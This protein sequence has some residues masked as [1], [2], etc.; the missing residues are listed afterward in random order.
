M[1]ILRT[2]LF[3]LILLALLLTLS[4]IFNHNVDFWVGKEYGYYQL[5][6]T[7]SLSV[8]LFLISK[9]QLIL[10]KVD[11]A[12]IS[13]LLFLALSRS[14]RLN[15]F[16]EIHIINTFALIF[17]YLSLK[18][19]RLNKNEMTTYYQFI[20]G[21]GI[22]LCGYC[23]LELFNVIEPTKFYWTITG[24][25]PNPGPL[26]GFI[27]LILPLVFYELVQ[28][29]ILK[30]PIKL[31]LYIISALLMLFV[32]IKSESRAAMLSTVIALTILLSYYGFK[33]WKYFK[34][35][36][37]TLLPIISTIVISK[38]TGSINGRLL[39][40]KISLLSFLENPFSGVGY[41][42]F[43]VEYS[44]FQAEYFSKGG[45]TE[46]ILLAGANEQAFNEFL[47]FVVENGVLG[48]ILII[49]ALFWISQAKP[50]VQNSDKQ[51][52]PLVSIAFY[53]S[54]AIFSF[55]SFPLQF[56]AFKLLLLNQIG[57]QNYTPLTVNFKT[58]K[59]F[60]KILLGSAAC[61]LL[62]TITSHYKAF[63]AWKEASELQFLNP[64]S[65]KELF[66]LAYQQL[67]NDGIFLLRYGS[68]TE[69]KNLNKALLLYEK[70][71][72]LFNFP[73]LY[74]RTANLY[75]KQL[76]YKNAEKNL[77]KIHYISPHFA[78][79]FL[80]LLMT[81]CA[82]DKLE[83]Q[84]NSITN[85]ENV[86]AYDGDNTTIKGVIKELK[87]GTNRASLER[88]LL[89]NDVLWENAEPL[90]IEDKKRILVPFLSVDKENIIGFFALYRDDKGKTQYDMTV[91]SDVYNKK[92]KLP[93]WNSSIWAGYFTAYDRTILGKRNGNPGVLKKA[94]PK[95]QLN[96]MT[97][98]FE[99][100]CYNVPY[101]SC[102]SVGDD[103]YDNYTGEW[104]SCGGSSSTYC[105]TYYNW[106][107]FTYW[108]D[109]EPTNPGTGDDGSGGGGTNSPTKSITTIE[110]RI[111]DLITDP[112]TSQ[113]FTKLKNLNNG[114]IP[115]MLNHFRA[116]GTIF[117]LNISIGNV[118]QSG[119]EAETKIGINHDTANI[120]LNQDYINGTYYANRP[121]DLSIANTITHEIIHAY[122]ISIT[123]A[124][125][126]HNDQEL[127]NSQI[128][129]EAYKEYLKTH[130]PEILPNAH[131][132]YIA[133]K[134]VNSIAATIKEFH[135]GSSVYSS[136][137]LADQVYRD[138][139]WAGLFDT[140]I[141]N[142]KYPNDPGNIHFT[143]RTRI[144]DRFYAERNG[145][146]RGQ[147]ITQGIPCPK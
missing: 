88:R 52:S 42:F 100:S 110:D 45:T 11:I 28:K 83:V 4:L 95:E 86:W 120:V 9:E 32:L 144:L 56:L 6:L 136:T 25:F 113:V 139:A 46:E 134:Y 137:G 24:N 70:A 55:F 64:D 140:T 31:V 71:K 81:S 69:E 60:Q 12:I 34:Y 99:T 125:Q 94:I 7:V 84:E 5:F 114:D 108:V 97:S 59:N 1:N 76:D 142:E 123:K 79:V 96:A 92:I 65:S 98:R 30:T 62:F 43:G 57:L 44:N 48:L 47:K 72:Q 104:S 73:P 116:N 133:D 17:Y 132:E 78:F 87:E 145:T 68:F 23:M 117:D 93:F 89:R 36:L 128:I 29:S 67:Q 109:D 85:P 19:L 13:L 61:L 115:T 37:L 126:Y 131:H 39:I 80:V 101:T 143:E 102:V 91:R 26:G 129:F 41:G 53:S 147:S 51:N 20:I 82:T 103:C 49:V 33:K 122:L 146:T 141:F 111:I 124:Y 138:L 112:C 27:A 10:G 77:L 90:I 105:S 74:S 127:L 40:W 38:G 3:K 21:V 58:N 16:N 8:L 2:N 66:N 130:N 50:I 119:N 107:C 75:E 18:T 135:T 118:T 14:L 63:K 106:E 121:T 35:T 54:F 15:S 22:L